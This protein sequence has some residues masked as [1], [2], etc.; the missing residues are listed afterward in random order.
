MGAPMDGQVV[1][2]ENRI[3][4]QQEQSDDLSLIGNLVGHIYSEYGE[5]RYLSQNRPNLL[6]AFRYEQFV[7]PVT[8]VFFLGLLIQDSGP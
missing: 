5:A 2:N 4:T 7:S 3:A 1:R 8:M 6:Q